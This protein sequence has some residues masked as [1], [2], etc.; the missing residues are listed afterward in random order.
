MRS[1]QILNLASDL[2]TASAFLAILME[3]GQGVRERLSGRGEGDDSD[4]AVPDSGISAVPVGE[5][6]NEPSG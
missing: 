2:D 6:L 4:N 1:D 5:Q 3:F